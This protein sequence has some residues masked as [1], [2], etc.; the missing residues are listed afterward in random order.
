MVAR[1]GGDEFAILARSGG[2]PDAN[3]AERYI[4]AFRQPF[5]IRD[6]PI[7]LGISIGIAAAAAGADAEA[8]VRAADGVLYEAKAAGRNTW[9]AAHRDEA[10]GEGGRRSET[11]VPGSNRGAGASPSS[12]SRMFARSVAADARSGEAACDMIGPRRPTDLRRA[13]AVL[14]RAPA[15]VG[16][17]EGPLVW[18]DAARSGGSDEAFDGRAATSRNMI[19][20]SKKRGTLSLE[21]PWCSSWSSPTKSLSTAPATSAPSTPLP[22]IACN[23]A[24]VASAQGERS[25]AKREQS[26]RSNC[27]ARRET[28]LLHKP[29]NPA[30]VI[31]VMTLHYTMLASKRLFNGVTRGKKLV[32]LVGQRESLG[33]AVGW[34]ATQKMANP[35]ASRCEAGTR[36]IL[37]L[38]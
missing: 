28:S 13:I 23:P 1:L 27:L 32:G 10:A 16:G 31:A 22:P 29:R 6:L 34:W 17:S 36:A 2:E 25:S 9:R 3:L 21:C 11:T 33:I 19:G 7:T 24:R 8:L 14:D 30:I 12:R 4:G 15:S 38:T 18:L 20:K 35:D 26:S 37:S 5:V